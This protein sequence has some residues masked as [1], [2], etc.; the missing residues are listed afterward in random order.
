MAEESPTLAEWRKLYKSAIR[1]KETAP[2]EWMTETDIFG[3]QN[4]ETGALGFVSVMGMLGEHYAIAVYLGA[5]GLYRFWNLQN[6]A[7]FA[8]PESLLEIPQLQAFFADRKEL[9]KEDLEII[10]ALGPKIRGQHAWPMFRSLRPGFFPWFLEA[11]ETRF[12]TV[13][14]EQVPDVTLRYKA[15]AALLKPLDDE[16]YLIRVP[17]QINDT[18]VWN[19]HIT[20][21]PPPEPVPIPLKMDVQALEAIK[22]LPQSKHK[23]EIDL[24]MFLS[25]VK[26]KDQRP[27][28][29]Y[30]LM[31]VESQSGMILCSELLTPAPSL[32]AM[33]G[34]VPVTVVR[35]LAQ[36]GIVPREVRVRSDLLVQLLQ[37][38]AEDLR[39]KLKQ[40]H[41]LRSLDPA[42]EFFL[43]RFM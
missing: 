22:H 33:W 12:L 31:I 5:Y 41:K 30:M 28:Y 19:D 11:D 8:P 25:P 43:S 1:V 36:V 2:W 37:P 10:K 13:V 39:F 20:R 35:R 23:I 15:D 42:K 7:P 40:S 3:V 16:S 24:F 18:F 21:V 29:P 6:I 32:E 9:R 4:P 27:V 34:L 38:L 17:I 14:L 26:E